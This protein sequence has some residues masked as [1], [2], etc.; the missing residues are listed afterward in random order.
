MHGKLAPPNSRAPDVADYVAATHSTARRLALWQIAGGMQ[1]SII[2]TCL[3][4]HDLLAT[5]RKHKLQVDGAAQSYDIHSYCV[6]AACQNSP[7]SRTLTK[8][9]D[10]RFA[11]AIRLIGRSRT[12]DE[13]R[14]V[15]ERLRDSGRIAAGYWA[16]MSDTHVPDSIRVRV[17][18]EVHMLS[19][20]NGHGANQLALRLAEAERRNADLEARLK[21]CE[22]SKHLALAERNAARAA[23]TATGTVADAPIPLALPT[24]PA[25]RIRQKLAKCERAL[26]SARA[27]ARHAEATIARLIARPT[28]SRLPTANEATPHSS[29]VFPHIRAPLRQRRILYL[30]GRTAVV[31]H[32]RE[33][34]AAR[35]A[36]LLH[37][38]GGIEDSLHRINDLIEACDVVICPV[39][40]VSHGACR[41]AKTACQRLNKCFLPITTAS[42][43]GFERA[44][45]VL[46][47]QA[48]P[49]QA[50][51][52]KTGSPTP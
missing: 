45:D 4:D 15:W 3:S 52:A 29:N 24:Q 12:E 47:R 32:L 7:F 23:L 26:V 22:Q 40:C 50:S 9:L 1:C 48:A 16:V 43:S 28:L 41:V 38:D 42:R 46:S 5:I 44:L 19:H 34:A 6:R 18:G 25:D 51:F 8:L 35:Q 14:A 21:R 27:R 11:G 39:D 20:L 2:G 13:M 37:H 36:F 30:G 49:D 31:P 17:F 33:A 10:R